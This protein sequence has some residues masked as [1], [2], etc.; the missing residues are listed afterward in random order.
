MLSGRVAFVTGGGS[1]IGRATCEVLAKDGAQ[2]VIVD[3]NE[4]MAK[5]TLGLLQGKNH[6]V[7]VLDI[8]IKKN[9]TSAVDAVIKQYNVPP[10]IVANVAGIVIHEN[11]MQ[12]TEEKFDRLMAVNVK[13]TINVTQAVCEK[14]IEHK[15]TGSVINIGSFV[16]NNNEMRSAAYAAGKAGLIALTKCFASQLGEHNIRVNLIHPGMIITPLL[17]A[18]SDEAL[19]TKFSL[20][21]SL[22][23]LGKAEGKRHPL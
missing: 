6:C 12:I 11:P 23:R 4:K 5:E 7:M 9:V 13:G 22:K 18:C 14:L 10:C 15:M 20:T 1:G 16:W 19:R 21:L 17:W 2:V 3:V 8:T